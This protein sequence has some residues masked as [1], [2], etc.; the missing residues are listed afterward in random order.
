MKSVDGEV[1]QKRPHL[2]RFLINILRRAT[3]KWPARN[4]SLKNAKKD[5]G[6]FQCKSCDELFKQK[7]VC[8][9]HI[10]PVVSPK[11]GFTT[12]DEYI[13]KMF[14]EVEGFQVLCKRCHDVKTE[15]EDQMRKY[16]NNKRK[17]QND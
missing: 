12:W 16:H 3:Y 4:D 6:L 8:I 15:L 2:K 13:E 17:E 11:T 7:E 5:K 10:I 9:D 14:P 1:K